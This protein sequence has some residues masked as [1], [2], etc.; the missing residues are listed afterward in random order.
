MTNIGHPVVKHL[1]DACERIECG[2]RHSAI[3]GAAYHSPP[4]HSAFSAGK[5]QPDHDWLGIR[6]SLIAQTAH[7]QN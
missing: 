6:H 2:S 4:T 3:L 5:T 7:G 1:D